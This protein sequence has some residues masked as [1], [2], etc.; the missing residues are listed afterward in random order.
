MKTLTASVA[1][2][3]I[4]QACVLVADAALHALDAVTGGVLKDH[5]ET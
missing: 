1:P 5:Q 3:I 4:A 2:R